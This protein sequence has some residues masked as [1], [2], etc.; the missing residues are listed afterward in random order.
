M[1]NIFKIFLII[2]L[3][4]MMTFGQNRQLTQEELENSILGIIE[5]LSPEDCE[6]EIDSLFEADVKNN[7][8]FLFLVSGINS[9]THEKDDIFENKYQIY[10][11]DFGCISPSNEC[12]I[13]YNQRV[14]EF[15]NKKFGNEWLK[16]ICEDVI[17]FKEWRKNKR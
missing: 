4:P 1:P 6:S 3:T 11:K 5:F 12:M 8:I 7:S 10:Y 17:G 15:L 16:E 13:Q 2:L 14:F 9:V